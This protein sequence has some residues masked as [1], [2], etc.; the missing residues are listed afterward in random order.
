M[1]TETMREVFYRTL[2]WKLN[3]CL[4]PG[5]ICKEKAIRAH[6]VQNA[7]TMD[8]LAR[9]G[10]VKAI[11]LI[12]E[13][14]SGP[15]VRFEDVG[16]NL[17]STFEGFCAAHDTSLFL[18]IDSRPLDINNEQQLFLYAYRS[19]A[20]ETHAEIEAA[21]KIQ[22][23]YQYRI[24]IK[25]DIGLN[26]E[27]A[28]MEALGH[29]MNAYETWQYKSKLDKALLAH[30]YKGLLHDVILLDQ[31]KPCIAVSS[32]FSLEGR[33]RDS[34]IASRP[35]SLFVEASEDDKITRLTINVFPVS[36]NESVI[37]FSYTKDD[38]SRVRDFLQPIFAAQ[39]F[40]QKYLLSKLILMGC[41]NF[42]V[43]PNL[44]DSWSS[45]KKNAIKD[46]FWKTRRHNM[47]VEDQNLFLF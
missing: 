41:E 36:L 17:A 10:H 27:Q 8:L 30:R 18:P 21:S 4:A 7:R 47:E 19:I 39:G 38:S 23:A 15:S 11:K 37:I 5:R 3:R 20:R 24:S 33:H 32:F 9:N 44:Y 26:S 22:S 14:G 2:N 45:E 16:R 46:F 1:V 12:I 42:F 40:Y 31:T 29:M 35:D 34:N 13:Q 6:S 28:G 25:F 43:S